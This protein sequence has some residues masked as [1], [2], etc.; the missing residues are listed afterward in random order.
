MV[1]KSLQTEM[2]HSRQGVGF[3]AGKG[4]MYDTV[5][6][7]FLVFIRESFICSGIYK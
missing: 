2:L 3:R 4:S 5:V 6:V 7:H 1:Y